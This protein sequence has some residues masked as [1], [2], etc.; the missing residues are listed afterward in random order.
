VSAGGAALAEETIGR[1]EP[2]VIV[3]CIE[4]LKA[5]TLARYPSGPRRRFNQGR[6]T[7]CVDA[8]FTVPD[9]LPT[10]H[11]VGLFAVPRTYRAVVRFANA[12][13]AS[14]REPDIR[15]M[16]VRLLDVDGPN[17]VPGAGVVDFVLNSHPVMMAGDTKS[18]LELLRAN[19]AG[20]L[21]RV[22]YFLTH[23]RALG[24]A[25]AAR[26]TPACHLDLTYWSATPYL[27]GPGR[28]VKYIAAPAA[29]AR[30]ARPP[31]LT[32]T[33]LRDA[34]RAR[35]AG[36]EA[37][38]DFMIQFQTDGARMP[39]ED[40]SVEWK[41]DESPYR[42]VGRLRIPAQALAA[43]EDPPRGD[44]LAF[45]PWHCPPEHRPLGNMNRARREIYQALAAFRAA[46]AQT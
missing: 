16:A 35:L 36:G 19:E 5:A 41:R 30:S 38:F 13:S 20:G 44:T 28:A 9:G 18:F 4:F 10:E 21:R 7:A 11:R 39:I 24:I 14:D 12:A 25:R 27:F 15:G 26:S 3:E 43:V 2:A 32:D 40:A 1:D 8:E 22:L 17:L 34:M 29:G 6:E 31:A 33:Y 45:N 42:T 37:V 23:V 46:P